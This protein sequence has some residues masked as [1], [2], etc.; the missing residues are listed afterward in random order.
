LRN[1]FIPR[2]VLRH[3]DQITA[4]IAEARQNN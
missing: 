1:N 2:V 3:P 4:R